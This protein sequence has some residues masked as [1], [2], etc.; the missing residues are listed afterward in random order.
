MPRIRVSHWLELRRA[1]GQ[2]A[3]CLLFSPAPPG[4]QPFEMR[5][6][7]FIAFLLDLVEQLP[8][9][10]VAVFPALRR[11]PLAGSLYVKASAVPADDLN[12]GKAV[13]PFRATLNIA[14]LQDVDHGLPLKINDDS[15]VTR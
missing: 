12:S 14:I 8:A 6:T 4:Q 7:P 9:A 11:C 15:S 2:I 10:S 3:R 13:Q 1:G 5:V